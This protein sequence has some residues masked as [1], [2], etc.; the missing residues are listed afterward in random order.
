MPLIPE[1]LLTIPFTEYVYGEVPP[2]IFNPYEPVLSP[3]QSTLFKKEDVIANA[4]WGSVIV[5]VFKSKEV[6]NLSLIL[7][8]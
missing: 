4:F 3:V 7:N 8:S 1:V 5:T 6:P 2:A